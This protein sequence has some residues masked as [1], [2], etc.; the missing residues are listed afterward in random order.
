MSLITQ[1]TNMSVKPCKICLDDKDIFEFAVDSKSF[2]GYSDV[3]KVCYKFKKY[4]DDVATMFRLFSWT[5]KYIE[6]FQPAKKRR[7]NDIVYYKTD[8]GKANLQRKLDKYK[9]KMLEK[10]TKKDEQHG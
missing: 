8:K 1:G 9:A 3:C 2:D 5:V 10:A 4:K 6:Y 7:L